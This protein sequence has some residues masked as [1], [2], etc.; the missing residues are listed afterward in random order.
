VSTTDAP[1]VIFISQW[2]KI[3]NAEYELIERTRRTGFKIA[4]TDLLGF[5]VE[6]GECLNTA[7]LS[8]DYDFAVSLHYETPKFLNLPTFLWVAN[9]L[10][11]MHAQS[12]YRT[13]IFHNI[14]SYDDYLYNGSDFLK[15]QIKAA[16]GHEWR[17][18][19]L[20]FFG[21]C[22]RRAI[23][24]PR[25][26]DDTG[27]IDKI[28]Y[29]GVN[30]ERTTDK[31]G[32]AQGLLDLLQAKQIA[33]FYG[34]KTLL[35]I[36]PWAGFTSYRG[37]IPFDGSGI[38]SAIHEYR[39]ALAVSSPAHIKSRT[40][41][42]R[43]IE[44]FAAGVPVISDE[45]PHVRKQFGDLVYYFAG[46]SEKERAESIEAA[47]EQIRSKP[48]EAA[49][50]VRA[51]QALISQTYCYEATLEALAGHVRGIASRAT[52]ASP[53]SSSKV[54][55]IDIV[56]MDHDPY[57]PANETSA[58]FPNAE[59]IAVAAARAVGANGVRVRVLHTTNDAF[60]PP[61]AVEGVEWISVADKLPADAIWRKMLLGEKVA[62]LARHVDADAAAFFTQWDF[63]Q[64]DY[65]DSAIS[66]LAARDKLAAPALH[67]GG[68]FINP[69]D[70]PAPPNAQ[71]ILRN[72]SSQSMYRWSQNSIA[73]HQFGQFLVSRAALQR[74]DW[75][76]LSRFD[77]L[78]PAALLIE[79]TGKE[80]CVYRSR[81]LLL[82]VAYGYYHRYLDAFAQNDTKGFWTQQYDLLSNRMHEI[83]RLYDAF[84]EHG[85]AVAVIDRIYGYDLPPAPYV[86][87]AVQQVNQFLDLLRPYY[88]AWLKLKNAI[89]GFFRKH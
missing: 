27:G 67:V 5:E 14:R 69:L 61:K 23:I 6:S 83:N 8:A 12:T 13:H 78:L 63:P 3:K 68:F 9:P 52:P 49:E 87:P 28:F 21:A 38:F 54:W 77:I 40:S 72:N 16:I 31:S 62:H 75:E 73:E 2:P 64:L 1:R 66:W 84:H 89:R 56:L 11:F 22:S 85:E 7:N 60:V 10:E 25:R 88:R 81:H 76:R 24:E 29:C 65:L 35:H 15:N 46:D 41:S 50:R 20:S 57:A 44:A 55:S 36:D 37:E 19:G 42:S 18:S 80:L 48:A 74:L 51:A 79:A 4:V 59:H 71:V 30:W 86:D 34:P 82:R 39:A 58:P 17:D 45:N 43:S 26:P 47:F 33:E 32:R 70:A 53:S